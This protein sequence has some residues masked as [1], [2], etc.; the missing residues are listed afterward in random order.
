M[1]FPRHM[2]QLPDLGF[3]VVPIMQNGKLA[4]DYYYGL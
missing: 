2:K 4:I 3:D 1:R